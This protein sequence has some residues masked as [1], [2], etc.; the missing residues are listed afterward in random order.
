M[1]IIKMINLVCVEHQKIKKKK[2]Q[3]WVAYHSTSAATSYSKKDGEK[4]SNR[5]SLLKGGGLPHNL[6]EETKKWF[7]SKFQSSIESNPGLTCFVSLSYDWSKKTCIS[8]ATNQMG[9]LTNNTL[10]SCPF[11]PFRYL[12]LPWDLIGYWLC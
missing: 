7:W 11:P 5:E 12:F 6:W 3:S 10:I 1:E 9:S 2:T 8:L 4:S